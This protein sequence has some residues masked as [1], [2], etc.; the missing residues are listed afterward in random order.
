M[1]LNEEGNSCRKTILE[2]VAFSFIFCNFSFEKDYS[3]GSEGIFGDFC[4]FILAIYYYIL[5]DL[6]RPRS[7][8]L[9]LFSIF[10]VSNSS[11][12]GDSSLLDAEF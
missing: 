12:K 2:V 9:T 10:G 4:C 5:L 6:V 11:I 3:F 7:F 8:K 1:V